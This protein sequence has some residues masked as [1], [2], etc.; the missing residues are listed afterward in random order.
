MIRVGEEMTNELRT[1]AH[2]D[3]TL[4]GVLLTDV[5]D[6]FLGTKI[7]TNS[8]LTSNCPGQTHEDNQPV[9]GEEIKLYLNGEL[10]DTGSTD[11][12]GKYSFIYNFSSI[13][14]F[15]FN[16]KHHESSDYCDCVNN[17]AI[18]V[19]PMPTSLSAEVDDEIFIK[20][21]F[22]VDYDLIDHFEEE[23]TVG[24]I[25]L[26]E[27]NN[28]VKTVNVGETL[29]YTPPVAGLHDYKIVFSYD[30]SYVSSE[31]SFKVNV[32]K[33]TTDL[34]LLSNGKS[35]YTV[36]E[37]VEFTGILTYTD[38]DGLDKP[39]KN[40][41]VKVYDNNQLLTS[42]TTDND[43]EITFNQTLSEGTHLLQLKFN[44]TPTYYASTSNI[45]RV[46]VRSSALADI[47]LKLYPENK[48]LGSKTSTIPCHVYAYNRAGNP[49]SI[50]FKM[51][52]TYDGE[53]P[54]TFTTDNTG[55]ARVNVNTNAI[56]NCC[57][58]YLQ[59]IS[60]DDADCYSNVV[61]IRDTV[62]PEL[63]VSG[64]ILTDESVYS[65]GDD[66]I[67]INGY[68]ED[69]EGDPVPS[70]DLQVKVYVNGSSVRTL[71]ARTNVLGEFNTTFTTNNNIRGNDIT[72]KLVYSKQSGKYAAFNDETAVLFKQLATTITLES[73][74]AQAGEIITINGEV[75]DENNR[76]VN[77]A[78]LTSS[79]EGSSV[80]H[81]ISNG[82]F[83]R[84]INDLLTA[85]QHSLT[86]NLQEN[87]FYKASSK[88][89]TITVNKITP[90]LE[91]ASNIIIPIN[92][93][94]EI[95]FK[96]TS[97][98]NRVPVSGNV[99]LSRNN[100]AIVTV[101]ASQQILNVSFDEIG[102]YSCKVKYNGNNYLNT[103]TKNITIHVV[104]LT[105]EI[106]ANDNGPWDINIFD[107]LPSN[108]TPYE[109]SE[110][111]ITTENNN[112]FNKLI[113][114]DE[115]DYDISQLGED[116]IVLVDNSNNPN[117]L[118]RDKKEEDGE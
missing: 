38:K 35:V 41:S 52:S 28:L 72:F 11:D 13:G 82:L 22:E 116:D 4:D 105:A 39:L 79:L 8:S 112:N 1:Y 81:N 45:Y 78:T 95:P 46:R 110:Y 49:I 67:H 108:L 25:K 64:A 29:E 51:E 16:V 3:L 88:T 59:A 113:L 83:D 40:K 27:D 103:A 19:D 104:E 37:N 42:L 57:G 94:S 73:I 32:I 111:I 58:T 75:R 90:S 15:N 54:G 6:Y 69:C 55:W 115:A 34:L 36:S 33:Y 9:A 101:D 84:T 109:D 80:N 86:A 48:I 70:Q 50:D 14:N 96:V 107:E 21:S 17:Y 77:P 97:S 44:E 85:G 20:D 18:T 2:R 91:I 117:I 87:T 98:N 43:G 89:I 62:N 30:S 10:E 99:V 71:S 61:H 93:T 5:G 68:L 60:V 56:V 100:T 66:V 118:I 53:L 47:N 92:S 23:V 31:F 12:D 7:I 65:Y 102:E 106:I 74:T 26:Y 76:V 24:E 114:T 63:T